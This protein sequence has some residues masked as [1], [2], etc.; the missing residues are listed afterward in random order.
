MGLGCFFEALL[1]GTGRVSGAEGHK[2]EDD[3]E[4]GDEVLHITYLLM[5]DR[6]FFIVFCILFL[7]PIGQRSLSDNRSSIL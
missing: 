2:E 5:I 1:F 7:S 4:D 3:D 6:T